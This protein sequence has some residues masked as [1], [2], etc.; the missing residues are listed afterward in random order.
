MVALV[1]Q[2]DTLLIVEA[3]GVAPALDLEDSNHVSSNLG[4]VLQ[5]NMHA[6]LV[7][8]RKLRVGQLVHV[9]RHRNYQDN[10]LLLHG[11]SSEGLLVLVLAGQELDLETS[12]HLA[13]LVVSHDEDIWKTD[14]GVAIFFM[15]LG[16]SSLLP[17][18]VRL[19]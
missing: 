5:H 13:K 18:A 7:L 11:N 19:H 9:Q 15:T 16:G 12:V 10:V 8:L 3:I 17:R 2:M 6:A 4:V 1:Q 14:L